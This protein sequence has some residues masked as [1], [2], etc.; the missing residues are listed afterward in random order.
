MPL[1]ATKVFS[2]KWEG[3]PSNFKDGPGNPLN[4]IGHVIG[5][6]GK[7]SLLSCLI[8]KNLATNVMAGPSIRMQQTFA[9]FYIDL[10]LTDKGMAEW[11]EVIRLTFAHINKIRQKG[12]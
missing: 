6:E 9:G 12:A 3:F 5:H 7:N 10:T 11:Q 8:R 4:Y 2:I 1:K